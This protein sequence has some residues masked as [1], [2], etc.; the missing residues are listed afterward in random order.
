MEELSMHESKIKG[1]DVLLADE[2]ARSVE[3]SKQL[4]SV[5]DELKSEQYHSFNL[6]DDLYKLEDAKKS[7]EGELTQRVAEVE[8]MKTK[9]AEASQHLTEKSA[10]LK[11]FEEL[12][13]AKVAENAEIDARVKVNIGWMDKAQNLERQIHQTGRDLFLAKSQ[14]EELSKPINKLKKE[15]TT[16]QKQ[17]RQYEMKANAVQTWDSSFSMSMLDWKESQ[18]LLEDGVEHKNVLPDSHTV[19][20]EAQRTETEEIDD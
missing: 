7:L 3:L 5:E 9:L 13:A 1:I 14:N 12:V 10:K 15:L 4:E 19:A 6:A 2:E 8:E 11:E 16:A 18:D 17:V 20:M